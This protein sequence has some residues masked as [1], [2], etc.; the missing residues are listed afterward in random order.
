MSYTGILHPL[1]M[2]PLERQRIAEALDVGEAILDKLEGPRRVMH[3]Y[4]SFASLACV[5]TRRSG[6]RNVARFTGTRLITSA[7]GRY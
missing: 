5:A 2:V 1:V 4:T 3:R 6:A 7:L